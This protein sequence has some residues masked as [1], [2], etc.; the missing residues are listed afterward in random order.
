MMNLEREGIFKARILA[1][2][3]READSGAVSVNLRL[4][5]LAEL[6]GTAWQSWEGFEE[7]AVY[8]DF[9]VVKKDGTVNTAAVEQLAAAIGWDGNLGS[10]LGAPP[11]KVVQVTVKA[12]TYKDVTRY[13]A[14]WI[15]PED[16]TPTP[17]GESEGD[18][19]KLQ[20]RFG[21]LLRAA[22]QG[23][24]KTAPP[25]KKAAPPAKQTA[26]AVTPSGEPPTDDEI[27][28]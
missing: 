9:Y 19:K 13:K 5:I 14:A 4:L 24:K 26:P 25:A 23:S 3:V 17:Q 7:H 8:G 11:D 15:N 20:A 16:Y 18:V 12:D 21:S 6:E 10:I 28:F 1:W 22:A 27:P 2:S